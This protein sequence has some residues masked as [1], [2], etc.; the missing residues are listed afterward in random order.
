MEIIEWKHLREGKGHNIQAYTKEFK[1]KEL[2]LGIPLYTHETLLNHI[3]DMH[4]Y[5]C[6][7]ILMF[8]PTKIDRVSVKDTHLEASKGKHE[9]EDKNPY[10]FKEDS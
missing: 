8:N 7:T 3:G 6:Y 10:K 1:K 2:S 9:I 5:M 4:S